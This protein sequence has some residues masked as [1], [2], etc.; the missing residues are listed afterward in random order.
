MPN[1][2]TTSL[3][4]DEGFSAIL[5]LKSIPQIL[6]IISRDTSPPLWNILEHLAFGIFGTS[7]VVVRGLAFS[8]FLGT[9]F[10]SYKIGA[11]LWSKKTGLLA[12]AFTFLNPFFFIYAFEGRMYSILALGVTASMYF[13][14]K[15]LRS[16]K[17]VRLSDKVGYI[18]A[19]LWAMYS[20]HFAIFALF[21]QGLWFVFEFILGKRK[22]AIQIFKSWIFVGVGY[23]PWVYPLYTQ[24][25]MVGGGFWLQTPTLKDLRNLIYDYL[26]EGIKSH[27][28]VFFGK[29]LHQITLWAVLFSLLLRRWFKDFKASAFLLSWFLGP[30]LLTWG[31]SQVF[32]SIFFNR[33]LLYVVPAAML[34]LASQR[35][36]VSEIFL[37]AIAASFIL[38]D[39]FYFTHP[40]KLAFRD[41]ASYVKSTRQPKDFIVNW[42]SNG[43]HHIWE[44]KYYGIGGPIYVSSEG[45]LPF[46]VGTALMEDGDVI[47]KLPQ[48]IDRVGVVTSGPVE[49]IS[50]PGYTK[51]IEQRF[52]SLK[53][54]WYQKR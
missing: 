45:D 52:G 35:R 29:S 14:L 8:F 54:V 5:S 49:E 15:I 22:N 1:Q 19:T 39:G 31:V 4:G 30:I 32:Q 17:R 50:L 43:T 3:W 38:I 13:F 46:F 12:A 2:F 25:R 26:A 10:F 42:Y 34:V 40:T 23:L 33:Y 18:I 27:P 21:I 6:S 37:V 44:T 36:K 48:N 20:H 41:L 16:E 51:E 28:Y 53:F 24:I 11:F 7:E 47:N 9:V